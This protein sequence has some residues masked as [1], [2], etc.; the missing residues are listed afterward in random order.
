MGSLRY[1][2]VCS[3]IEAATVAWHPLGWVPVAFA[4]IEPFASAVLAH[5]FPEVPNLGDFTEIQ[6]AD[7]G[8]IDLLV[9]GT[10]CQSFSIAGLRNSLN[11]ERGNL[12]LQFIRIANAIDDIRRSDGRSPAYILWENVPGVLN[13]RDNAFGT[14][15]AGLVGSDTPLVS[16]NG[17]GWT[18]AGVV[19][20]PERCA[21]WRCLDAQHFGLAQRRKR[22]FVLARRHP[23]GWTCADALLPVI[24]SVRWHSAPRRQARKDAASDIAPCL[25]SGSNR[26]GGTRPPGTTVD[27]AESLIAHS[28]TSRAGNAS[29]PAGGTGNIIAFG[30][31]NTSG[32]LDV[33]TAVRAKGGSGHMDFES[34]TFVVG[35]MS[36]A[37]GTERKHGHGWGQQDWENG[38]CVPT[39]NPPDA[40]AYRTSPNCGAW[41]TGDKVDAL[42]TG[43]DP[44]SHV[45]ALSLRGR[46]GGN[47][48]E[49]SGDVMP[50]LRTGGG[51]SDK[52]HIL[53]FA[54]NSRGELRLEGGDGGVTGALSTDGGK[55]GQGYPVATF[56]H[57]VRRLTPRECERLQGF[58][59]D[60]T[61]VPY[62]GRP[63]ADGPRYR[64]IGNSFAVPVIRWIGERIELVE[65]LTA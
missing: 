25:E 11:D 1:L 39:N 37:G 4:E 16:P 9:G 22:V 7:V 62:R 31:N 34:E 5:R 17:S 3:G 61:L 24:E 65:R 44:T 49:L 30:G 40:T 28:I 57:H 60:F 26:T 33:A 58:P 18:D 47:T 35:T 42:T 6:A 43:T 21:A 23:R 10:P 41:E 38:Y 45:L 12:T 8:P 46:E 51:G 52:P 59:D 54:E 2:S 32:P 56:G 20:G 55:P 64:V 19:A 53:A 50:A 48:V 14:F 13:T 29:R 63:A 15:L 36:S 27:T